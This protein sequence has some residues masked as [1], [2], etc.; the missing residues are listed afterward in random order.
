MEKLIVILWILFGIYILVLVMILTDLWSG[1]T[2][3]KKNG[4]IR[5][6]YGFRRTIEKIAR[7]YNVLLALT[8]VD[9]MQ[10]AAI[11]Y[12]ETYYEKAIP[13]FPF[14]TL[15]GAV[16]I[17]LIEIKSIYE[18]AEDKVRIDDVGNLVGKMLVNKD[19]LGE[20]VKS[21]A[22]Y[23]KAEHP[24]PPSKTKITAT[25]ETKEVKKEGEPTE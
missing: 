21:M 13:M 11:W 9:A 5:S 15:I 16:G 17:C 23:M 8:V 25:I 12:L 20:V 1:V 22:E 14:I 4:V 2:K 10:V 6:S 24:S 19:D 18:K 3:A 7:Y